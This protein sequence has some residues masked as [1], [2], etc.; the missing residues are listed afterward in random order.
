MRTAVIVILALLF[1][2]SRGR[3]WKIVFNVRREIRSAVRHR[4]FSR[5][6]VAIRW[7]ELAGLC[8]FVLIALPISPSDQINLEGNYA[9]L[10]YGLYIITGLYTL[11]LVWD[12]LRLRKRFKRLLH[13]FHRA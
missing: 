13:S 3:L 5:Y 6:Y 9:W 11:Y 1:L 12:I 7:R 2:V 4:S 10:L 8:G